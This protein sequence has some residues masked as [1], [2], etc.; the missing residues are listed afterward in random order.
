MLAAAK[1]GT[2][3][4]AAFALP[5]MGTLA[6]HTESSKPRMV[7]VTPTRELAMQISETCSA[8]AR[9]TG[10]SILTVV[11]GLSYDP[12]INGLRAGVDVL[13]ATPGRL[14]DLMKKDAV[15]LSDVDVLVL[16]EADRMVDMGFWPQVSE[17]VEAT[18]ARRQT[19]LFSA[20]IDSSVEGAI[21]NLLSNPVM[22]VDMG[23]WPQVSEI[24]EATP[25]RR[26][27]LLFSA[28]IDSSV[29]GAIDNLLSNPV[30]VEIA[31]KGD[32]ADTIDQY[33]IKTPRRL[34]PTLLNALI[35][36]RGSERVI[37]F[38]RTKGCADNCVRR[39]RNGGITAE[40]IHANRSQ[41]Q[42]KHALDNF[43]EGITDV[44]VATDV[45]ARGIDI[46][47]VRYVVN[48]DLPEQ[49]EDYV[50]RIGRTGRAGEAGCAISFVMPETRSL[51]KQIQSFIMTEIPE[52]DMTADQIV[53]AADLLPVLEPVGEPRRRDLPE[54]KGK[55]KGKGKGRK[56]SKNSAKFEKGR[57]GKGKQNRAA[58]GT[59]PAHSEGARGKDGS[60]HK[61]ARTA[62]AARTADGAGSP[63]A[64]SKSGAATH[65]ETASASH[66]EAPVINNRATRREAKRQE[67]AERNARSP[68]RGRDD[69]FR[70]EGREGHG[71]QGSRKKGARG[72]EARDERRYRDEAPKG[73]KSAK[74]AKQDRAAANRA[75]HGGQ[76]SRKKG[77]RG[78]EARDERRY[79]D[80]APKG[81][82][83]AK[84]AKQDRAA[85]NRAESEMTEARAEL[86][87]RENDKQRKRD[88][89]AAR[90]SGKGAKSGPKTRR[91]NGGGHNRS[92]QQGSGGR[93]GQQKRD[94]RPGRGMRSQQ[95]G[96]N[97]Y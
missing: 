79:R 9:H 15:D 38:T 80:E 66:G 76:G 16:D 64:A 33:I 17:I 92:S 78:E 83:S 52:L 96:G 89:A 75:G 67:Y 37:V 36:T 49:I 97:R 84:R 62:D 7:V 11:G 35:R 48:Y 51:L 30:M 32:V 2:G 60:R 71:G 61:D 3:K 43:R 44:L 20:T 27:T 14:I 5:A 31:R 22:M 46:S 85:A 90:Q 41:A 26:Q 29:E 87:K 68:R 65:S 77:A 1:T 6:F 24:V 63:S 21:D 54:G 95:R 10:H 34:R 45:L 47:E 74:R 50:H 86:K 13:I 39:L 82:K 40:A 88:A 69:E 12:Q 73:G 91:S 93:S 23:F 58:D 94:M 25:A 56:G 72:E 81:G 18:P 57:S 28:T 53:S 19:L 55:G 42:R 59:E 4:T 8:I 70:S